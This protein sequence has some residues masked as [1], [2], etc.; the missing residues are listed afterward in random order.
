MEQN[1]PS[2]TPEPQLVG[3]VGS[4]HGVISQLNQSTYLGIHV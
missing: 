4:W 1:Q 3:V 2:L